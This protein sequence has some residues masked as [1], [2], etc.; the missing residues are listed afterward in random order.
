MSSDESGPAIAT[1]AFPQLEAPPG[2]GASPRDLLAGA[3]TQAEQ[4][5]AQAR[6]QGE[7][8]GRAEGL[9]AADHEVESALRALRLA[10]ADVTEMRTELTAALEQDAVA[11]AFRI[12]EQIL[13]AAI[14][15]KSELIIDV[16]RN[17]LRRVTDRRR[18]ILVVN[19]AD[20]ETV[21][22]SVRTLRAE[23]GGIDHCDV[24]ADRRIGRGGA[25]LRTEA[26]EIDVTIDSQLERAREIVA[27]T[28]KDEHD[29]A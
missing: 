11:L 19:P 25:I 9:R 3:W 16:A 17:A 12:A 28:L 1:Y 24:Q 21:A 7:A 13:G 15:V 23:L 10:L 2:G 14:D 26:G 6:S 18:V 20:L 27:V 29:G 4:I 5:R 22:D 8:E